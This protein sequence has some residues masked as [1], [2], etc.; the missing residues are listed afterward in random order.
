MKAALVAA[1]LPPVLIYHQAEWKNAFHFYCRGN[2]GS[3]GFY[4][5]VE[6]NLILALVNKP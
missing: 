4:Y 5:N 6:H 2:G 3:T 1:H